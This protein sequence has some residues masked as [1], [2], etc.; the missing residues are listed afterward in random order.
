MG[1]GRRVSHERAHVAEGHGPRDE[2]YRVVD[3]FS[4]GEA[5]A[6]FECEHGAK[7]A[8]HLPLCQLVA[9]VGSESRV[10]HTLDA[11]VR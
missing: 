5:T 1:R 4:G 10:V 3:A 9:G 8:A 2:L 7:A 6:D 11:R